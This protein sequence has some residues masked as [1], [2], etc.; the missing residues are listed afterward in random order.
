LWRAYDTGALVYDDG[1][2]QWI[3]SSASSPHHLIYHLWERTSSRASEIKP[4]V[5]LQKTT[6]EDR[7]GH[8]L[9]TSE[10][11][12]SET[13]TERLAL[14]RSVECGQWS[15]AIHP[16][17]TIRTRICRRLGRDSNV[18]QHHPEEVPGIGDRVCYGCDSCNDFV[19]LQRDGLFVTVVTSSN[20]VASSVLG[21]GG[22]SVGNSS[23]FFWS[24]FCA[25][26]T[27]LRFTCAGHI[28]SLHFSI[29]FR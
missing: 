23:G 1:A 18:V 11:G 9:S 4:L 14:A 16:C 17:L 22:P 7:S 28:E 19:F 3:T 29:L 24:R 12:L 5:C 15:T 27:H 21:S 13:I 2:R 20:H 25:D 8:H 10:I 6:Q 26:S